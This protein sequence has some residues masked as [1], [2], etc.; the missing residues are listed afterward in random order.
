MLV[1]VRDAR[2]ALIPMQLN[3]E[4]FFNNHEWTRIDTKEREVIRVHSCLFAVVKSTLR[5]FTGRIN[6]SGAGTRY[7][8]YLCS[9]ASSR[10]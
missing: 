9:K 5:G 7:L 10:L 2:R 4:E 3:H 8:R 6:G 1:I